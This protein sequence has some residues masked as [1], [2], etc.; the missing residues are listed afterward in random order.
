[1]NIPLTPLR[2]LRYAEQQYPAR[3]AVVC[4]HNRFTYA[5][6]AERAARLELTDGVEVAIQ[7]LDAVVEPEDIFSDYP[8]FSSYSA[9]WSEHARRFAAETVSS[10]G[11]G[12]HSFVGRFDELPRSTGRGHSEV[13]G[14]CL[15]VG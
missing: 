12:A 5:Q 7:A 8:Y 14:Y 11:L 2:F 13:H 4:N 3:T 15:A 10:L 9:T 6:F 1:M